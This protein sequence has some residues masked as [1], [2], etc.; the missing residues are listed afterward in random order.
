MKKGYQIFQ[1]RMGKGDLDCVDIIIKD[2]NY[3]TIM[4]YLAVLCIM[5]Q[6]Y[7]ILNNNN[8]KY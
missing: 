1:T 2:G 3:I 5:Q 8:I 7:F 4:L 6:I